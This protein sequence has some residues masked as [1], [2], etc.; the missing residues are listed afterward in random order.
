VFEPKL[1][2]KIVF[3]NAI[4]LIPSPEAMG[5]VEFSTLPN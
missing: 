5:A 2:P 4:E 1:C 3:E